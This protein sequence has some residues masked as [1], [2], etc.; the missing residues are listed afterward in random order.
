MAS[1]WAFS[2][3][4]RAMRSS[5]SFCSRAAVSARRRASS[6]WSASCFSRAASACCSASRAR[7]LTR[8]ASGS[9]SSQD[10]S[11][12]R[13]CT[14]AMV[15]RSSFASRSR[16][17]SARSRNHSTPCWWR[18]WRASSACS[19]WSSGA[20]TSSASA[21]RVSR[22]RLRSASIFLGISFRRSTCSFPRPSRAVFTLR[23]LKARLAIASRPFFV[24]R[25]GTWPV[26]SVRIL[27]S[28]G[29]RPPGLE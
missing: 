21:S 6:A 24:L 16:F 7:A 19:H 11:T 17:S 27:S 8:C 10:S 12:A 1:R 18:C 20:R 4:S 25:S 3:A 26:T 15:A 23:T 14:S 9:N 13:A 2:A 28:Q 29:S 5:R 22:M